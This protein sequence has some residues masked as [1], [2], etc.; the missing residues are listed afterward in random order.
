[1]ALAG[2]FELEAH[3]PGEKPGEGIFDRGVR[4]PNDYQ[5]NEGGRDGL[6]RVMYPVP[7]LDLL[8]DFACAFVPARI[9]VRMWKESVKPV[10]HAAP[11]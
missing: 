2:S 11:M 6:G 1:M 4:A 10:F 7:S 8:P 9:G 3:A 5:D